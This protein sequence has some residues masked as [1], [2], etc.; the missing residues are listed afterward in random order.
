MMRFCVRPLLLLLPRSVAQTQGNLCRCHIISIIFLIVSFGT[1]MYRH[2]M[3]TVSRWNRSAGSG[4]S[5]TKYA[6]VVLLLSVD[7]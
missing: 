6:V 7:V 3:C 2:S 5:P 4:L 1:N